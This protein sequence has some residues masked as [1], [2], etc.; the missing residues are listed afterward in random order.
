MPENNMR[1]EIYRTRFIRQYR[2]RLVAGNNEIIAS[3]ESYRA[4]SSCINA[5]GLV[6]GAGNDTPIKEVK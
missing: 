5:I 2:W 1:F 4:K 6:K 3:G